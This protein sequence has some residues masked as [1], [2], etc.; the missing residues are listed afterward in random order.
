MTKKIVLSFLKNPLDVDNNFKIRKAFIYEN[1]HFKKRFYMGKKIVFCNLYDSKPHYIYLRYI[2]LIFSRGVQ[3]LRL[4]R[5]LIKYMS[6][7]IA[8]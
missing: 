7:L 2:S 3:F 8:H 1:I 5:L 6:L 4:S